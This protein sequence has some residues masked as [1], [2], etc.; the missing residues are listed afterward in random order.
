MDKQEAIKRLDALEGEAKKLREIIETGDNIEYDKRK[1]YV[2]IDKN[3]GEP[4]LLA[5]FGTDGAFEWKP[6]SGSPAIRAFFY[7]QP[8]AQEAINQALSYGKVYGFSDRFEG[9]K[10]F[11]DAYMAGKKG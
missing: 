2:L 8:T 9:M 7:K 6:F 3:D 11:Y 5:S 1:L 4:A 10:F